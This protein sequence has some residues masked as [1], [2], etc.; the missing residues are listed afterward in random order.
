MLS[1]TTSYEEKEE[2]KEVEIYPIKKW[3]RFILYFCDLVITFFFATL[4]FTFAAVPISKAV[5]S[6]DKKQDEAIIAQKKRNQILFDVNLLYQQGESED[7]SKEM[8]YTFT[9]YVAYLVDIPNDTK[10]VYP[11]V[12]EHFYLDIRGYEYAKYKED[13]LKSD[14]YYF[15][16]ED[17]F[18]SGKTELKDMFVEQFKVK[19]DESDELLGEAKENY[20]KFYNGFFLNMYS[21][22]MKDIQ[23]NDLS[24]PLGGSTYMTLQKQIDKFDNLF[25]TMEIIDMFSSF[26][27]S[28]VISY[29]IVPLI[30]KN[31]RTISMMFMKLDRVSVSTLELKKRTSV[32][33]QFIYNLATNTWAIFFLSI[34][35]VGLEYT[36]NLPIVVP[37]VLSSLVISIISV[38]ILIFDE[39]NR[40]LSDRFSDAVVLT[41]DSLDDIYRARGYEI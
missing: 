25:D 14:I 28:L 38:V 15:F 16:K 17:S 22:V 31:R 29:V 37:L 6:F 26:G 41:T 11:N 21:I 3:K 24:S 5:T 33:P 8:N 4:L 34:I 7:L 36:F 19:F 27:F 40:P 20:E 18:D 12:F 13:M 1:D 2:K 39:Y 30:N 9:Q 32:L 35:S 10:V 23:L